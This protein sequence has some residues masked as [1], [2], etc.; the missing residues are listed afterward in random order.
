MAEPW[1]SVDDVAAYLGVVKDSV[2]RWIDRRG[3]PAIKIGKLWKL[4]L[5]EVDAWV[6]ATGETAAPPSSMKAPDEV[7]APSIAPKRV[8]MVVDDDRLVRETIGDF[9][10]DL[11]FAALLASDGAVAL[12]LLA[13]TAPRPALIVLDLKMPNLDGWQFREAQAR[14]PDLATIPMVVVTAVANA[15]V[16][17]AL[18]LRKPLR[19]P[20]L[21]KAIASLLGTSAG[22]EEAFDAR[23][24]AE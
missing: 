6:R 19:L 14:H 22:S 23:P 2:Y 5:S 15:S 1:V 20:K 11:G 10:T 17:G 3:L 7:R 12:T 8:V 18:V 16:P 4:K 9:L 13:T 21:A 24:Q